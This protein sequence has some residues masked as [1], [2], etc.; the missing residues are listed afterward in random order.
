MIHVTQEQA[1]AGKRDRAHCAA[2]P[3][4]KAVTRGF[5]L[6]G[7]DR[8]HAAEA[9]EVGLCRECEQESDAEDRRA[10]MG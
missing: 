4:R 9:P 6:V 1:T 3:R 2:H 7:G 5:V 10:G 8:D